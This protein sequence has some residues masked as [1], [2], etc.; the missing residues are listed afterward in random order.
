MSSRAY[1]RFL[2]ILTQYATTNVFANSGLNLV[3]LLQNV[4]KIL[5]SLEHGILGRL[6]SRYLGHDHSNLAQG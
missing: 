1:S 5:T 3:L 6:K 4:P 2:P